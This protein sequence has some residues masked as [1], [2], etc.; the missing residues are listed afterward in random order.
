MAVSNKYRICKKCDS[1]NIWLDTTK[2]KP[3]LYCEECKA[4][5][6]DIYELEAPSLV[7]GLRCAIATIFY[8]MANAVNPD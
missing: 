6:E 5:G 2:A 8:K 4:S 1:E 3:E 7:K